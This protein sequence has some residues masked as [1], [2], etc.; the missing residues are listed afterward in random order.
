MDFICYASQL[1]WENSV[2]Y[3]RYYQR[4]SN[5]IQVPIST[6]KQGKPTSFQDMYALA[7]TIN[8]HYWE[9]DHECHC[10]RQVEKE[11][12]KSHSQK[13]GKASTSSSVMVSQSKANPFLVASS[14]KNSFSKLSPS[15]APKKQPNTPWVDLSFKL[16]SNDKLTSNKHKKYLEN[17]LYLY[18]DIG[19]YKLDFCS[20]KQTMVS[21]KN[22]STLAT[23]S[24]KPSEKWR[25]TSRTLH[26]LRA[27][28]N[29]LVQQ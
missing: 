26:R 14:T 18:Y 19:D 20:K 13:Q 6:W 17:N 23:A 25:A 24:K 10:T 15:S 22:H 21:P 4:L 9:Q 12:L 1:G 11:A 3:H 7:M 2:L 27:V 29:F 5:Q 16:A 28:L 8:H